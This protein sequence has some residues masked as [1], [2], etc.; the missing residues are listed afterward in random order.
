M[1]VG[2]VEEVREMKVVEVREVGD[3]KKCEGRRSRGR[4]GI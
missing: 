3:V 1:R 4:E 2:E